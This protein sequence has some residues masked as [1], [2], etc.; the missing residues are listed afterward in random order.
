[1]ESD[2]INSCQQPDCLFCKMVCGEKDVPILARFQHCFA[3]KDQYPVSPGHVL[4]IPYQHTDNWFTATEEVRLDM[5][6]ALN[7][8]KAMLDQEYKPDGYN[9][10][11]NCGLIAG[12]T[13]MHLHLHL[14]PRYKG[15]MAD[16]KGGV[17]GVIPSMQKY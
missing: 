11:A 15:D 13:V 8:V 17:R 16:P 14:I 2:F 12:Q 1:M 7:A 3:I 5:M 4:L 10:G 9:M 6:Q